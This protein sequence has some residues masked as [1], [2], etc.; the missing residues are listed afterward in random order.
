VRSIH[1]GGLVDVLKPPLLFPTRALLAALLSISL[2]SARNSFVSFSSRVAF[3]KASCGPE[4][5]AMETMGVSEPDARIRQVRRSRSVAGIEWHRMTRSKSPARKRSIASFTDD[6]D[7]T[8]YPA[9]RRTRLRFRNKDGSKPAARTIVSD[10]NTPAF[11][12]NDSDAF[13]AYPLQA[14]RFPRLLRA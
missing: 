12:K 13:E 1:R 5:S 14:D 4:V 6:A 7:T 8:M 11:D 2:R 9:D 10:M 3:A